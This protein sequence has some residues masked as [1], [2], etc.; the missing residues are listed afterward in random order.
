MA[1]GA[2]DEQEPPGALHRIA[3]EVAALRVSAGNPSLRRIETLVSEN[4]KVATASRQTISVILRARQRTRLDTLRAVVRQLVRLDGANGTPEHEKRVW[5]RI[6]GLWYDALREEKSGGA[7]DTTEASRRFAARMRESVFGP[8]G[9]DFDVIGDRLRRLLSAG[10]PDDGVTPAALSGVAQ[11]TRTPR[12]REVVLLLDLLARDGRPLSP[13]DRQALLLDYVDVLR[14]CAP[15]L[16]D[17]FMTDEMLD[18]YRDHT[19]W[20]VAHAVDAEREERRRQKLSHR[21]DRARLTARVKRLEGD[22]AAARDQATRADVALVSLREERDRLAALT[23]AQQ[24]ADSLPS[25]GSLAPQ[26]VI[27]DVKDPGAQYDYSAFAADPL[28]SDSTSDTYDCY[29]AYMA[30]PE[31]VRPD[32]YDS[33]PWAGFDTSAYDDAYGDVYDDAYGAVGRWPM[34]GVARRRLMIVPFPAAP[35]PDVPPPDL[36]PALPEPEP[37]PVGASPGSRRLLRTLVAPFRRSSGR[38]A[39]GRQS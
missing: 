35:L 13:E 27:A 37:E 8:L 38:H 28:F 7:P 12:R 18:A 11:G 24:A 20:L 17:Q 3:R 32:G 23:T 19:V 39:R 33:P 1:S 6:E 14:R 22:A 25:W 15:S 34:Y 4:E 16:Y 29:A 21:A 26:P 36:A 5:S 30:A 2:P 31:T 9:G 10:E